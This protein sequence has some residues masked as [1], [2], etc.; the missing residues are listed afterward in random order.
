[1]NVLVPYLHLRP[2]LPSALDAEQIQAT[3]VETDG[4]DG[5]WRTLK[6]WWGR[7]ETFIC[8][9]QDKVPAPG[10]LRRLWLCERP[11]CSPRVAMR[12]TIE[13][14]PYPPLACVK[15][16]AVLMK[17]YPRLL[18]D[19]GQLDMGLG[20]KEWS[21]LDLAIAGLLGTSWIHHWHEEER[22]EHLHE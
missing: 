22:V 2:E 8:L 21:R 1:M 7:G 3:Y 16:D 19:V 6:A 10:V 5:Y 18:D 13:P 15:F 17:D 11:W 20:E 4:W 14:A 9:E 12:G